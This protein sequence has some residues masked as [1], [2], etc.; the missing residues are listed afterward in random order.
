LSEE[1]FIQKKRELEEDMMKHGAN[2]RKYLED[3]QA[4]ERELI[5]PILEKAR[6]ILAKLTKEKG[7]SVVIE[8]TPMVLFASPEVDLTNDLIKAFESEK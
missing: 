7:I 8:N 2:K 5:V 4:K 6:K 3:M 1:A